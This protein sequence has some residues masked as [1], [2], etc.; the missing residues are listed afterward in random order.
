MSSV[1]HLQD[2][3]H[4]NDGLCF[5]CMNI[6]CDKPALRATYRLYKPF[7]G[8]LWICIALASFGLAVGMF[9][10]VVVSLEIWG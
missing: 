10:A 6:D 1:G 5:I 3:K 9:L 2:V 7:W 8:N 4:D